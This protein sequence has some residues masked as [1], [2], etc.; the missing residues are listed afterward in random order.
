MATLLG[1]LPLSPLLTPLSHLTA[2]AGPRASSLSAQTFP[3]T[4]HTCLIILVPKVAS[5]TCQPPR[6]TVEMQG[7]TS[8]KMLTQRLGME[9]KLQTRELLSLAP[10]SVSPRGAKDIL[11]VPAKIS[12]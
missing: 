5:L 3:V 2:T 4:T 6:M 1:L 9:S 8:R 7:D 12:K 10:S 11:A